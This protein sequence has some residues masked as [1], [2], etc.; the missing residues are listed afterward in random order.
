MTPNR[1]GCI[2]L[3]C[4]IISSVVSSPKYSCWASLLK[5]SNGSTANMILPLGSRA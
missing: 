5:F 2:W 3:S 1:P 4:V